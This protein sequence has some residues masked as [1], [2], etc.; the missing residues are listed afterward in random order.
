MID[1][2]ALFIT[3]TT[4]GTWLP[5]DARGYVSNTLSPKGG[6]EPKQNQIG[7]PYKVDEAYTRERARDLQKWQAVWLTV[8]QAQIVANSLVSVATKRDWMIL[9]ASVMS[10]H[11]HVVL[12][13]CPIDGPGVRRIL[14]G[15]TQADL[16]AAIGERRRWWTAGGSD[17]RRSGVRSIDATTR[18]VADQ[19]GKLAEV[20]ENVVIV[21]LHDDERRG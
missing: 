21:S 5:G 8:P 16:S 11:V 14:K 20:V 13:R 6:F 2:V 4:Y 18:Y 15:N 7:T 3:W 12:T 19:P 10:N 1:P 9:R 17:R